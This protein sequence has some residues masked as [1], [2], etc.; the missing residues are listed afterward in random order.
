MLA[1]EERLDH[2]GSTKLVGLLRA[3]DPRG[4]VAYARHAYAWHAKEAIR[5]LYDIPNAEMAEKYLAELADDRQDAEFPPEVQ[6]LGRTLT[7]WRTQIVNWHQCRAS[8]GPTEAVNNL[9]KRPKRCAFGFQR[10]RNYR[11]R[12][13]LHARRPHCALLA[14]ITPR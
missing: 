2:R 8:K 11:I 12:S 7:R 14:T 3:G 9:V 10:F 4:E 5:F 1:A 6:S 13:L